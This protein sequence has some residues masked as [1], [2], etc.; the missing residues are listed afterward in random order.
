VFEQAEF[1]WTWKDVPDTERNT[2][3]GNDQYPP[4]PFDH[5]LVKQYPADGQ[6]P[7]SVSKARMARGFSGVSDHLP[8]VVDLGR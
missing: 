7:L 2:W 6:E 3:V 8:V 1:T 4:T 5:I